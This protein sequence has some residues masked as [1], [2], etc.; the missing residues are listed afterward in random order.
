[1]TILSKV[2][3]NVFF[4]T[5]NTYINIRIKYQF[6]SKR[7]IH[8]S[9]FLFEQMGAGGESMAINKKCLDHPNVYLN[10]KNLPQNEIFIL[11]HYFIFTL[12]KPKF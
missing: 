8:I 9:F 6:F 10:I 5:G 2:Y 11:F 7:K 12:D 4:P 1:M 3:K